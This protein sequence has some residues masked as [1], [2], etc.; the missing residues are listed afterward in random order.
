MRWLKHIVSVGLLIAA[1]TVALVTG[2]SDHSGDYGQVGLPQGGTVHLPAGDVIIFYKQSGAN[3]DPIQLAAPVTFQVTSVAGTPV[4]MSSENGAPAGEAV[5]RSENI[6][7]L[8]A[9]AKLHV[10]VSGYYTVSGS[11]NMPAGGSFLKFGTNA[12]AALESKWHLL[13]GLVLGAFLIALI[14]VPK[15]KRRWEDETKPPTGWSSDPRAPYAG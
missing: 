12:G 4:P 1:A 5:Q 7:E 6:G 2:L 13:A 3:S 11:A 8:G 10:P 9:V 14:P 15:Q